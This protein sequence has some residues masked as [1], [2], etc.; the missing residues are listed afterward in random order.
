M[1]F[2]DS[3]VCVLLGTYNGERFL[4]EQLASL[5]AQTV[6]NVD[7]IVGDD[8]SSDGTRLILERFR[9]LWT[10]GTFDI[11]DGPRKGFAENFRFLSLRA[12]PDVDFLAFCDQDDVWDADK[13]EAAIAAL[14]PIPP[15][16]PGAYFSR[17]LLTDENDNA[18]GLS[19]LFSRPPS[20]RN[21][22][23]QSI[24]GGNTLVLNRAGSALFIEACRRTSFVTHDWWAYLIVSGAGGVVHYDPTPHIRYRQ[25]GSN[26]VGN[27]VGLAARLSRLRLLLGGRFRGWTDRNLAGLQLC[28]DLLSP[29]AGEILGRFRDAREKTGPLAV[30]ALARAGVHRQVPFDDFSFKVAVFLGKV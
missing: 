29:E 14:L 24:G 7:I 21:A 22:L 27:N 17:T 4:E 28:I 10:K 2:G 9:A 13:L 15:T 1:E 12:G 11:L 16:T 20:F 23:V 3:K 5:A 19:P 8:G 26:L 30:K 25:H 6:S 18:F